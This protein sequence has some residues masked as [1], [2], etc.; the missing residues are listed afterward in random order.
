MSDAASEGAQSA[1]DEK[2]VNVFASSNHDA[3]AEAEI[4]NAL[5]SSSGLRSMIVRQ[6][7]EVLPAGVVEV[8]VPESEVESARKI[9]AASKEA[10][11]GE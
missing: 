7:T 4:V 3:E 1:G 2:M 11:Q 9:L 6:N 5:L 8:R 10:G